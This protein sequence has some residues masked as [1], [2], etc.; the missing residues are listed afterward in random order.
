MTITLREPFRRLA[1]QQAS[2]AGYPT[3]TAY[4][5]SLI[6]R[7]DYQRETRDETLFALQAGLDDVADGRVRPMREALADLAR[8]HG[9]ATSDGS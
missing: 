5:E 3:V 2:D 1:E 7:A 6:E 9:I 4:F 8:K